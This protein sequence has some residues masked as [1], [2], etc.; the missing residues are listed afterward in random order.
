[1]RHPLKVD[2]LSASQR[3][4]DTLALVFDGAGK[5]ICELSDT[6]S[7][8][9]VIVDLDGVGAQTLL[10]EY[11]SQHP[12]RPIIALSVKQVN[13]SDVDEILVKPIKV[14][15][16]CAAMTR[17]AENLTRGSV[18]KKWNPIAELVPT[19]PAS[20]APRTPAPAPVDSEPSTQ[21]VPV[22]AQVLTQPEATEARLQPI[23]QKDYRK[24]CGN[25]VDIDLDDTGQAARILMPISGRLLGIILY[26][27]SESELQQVPI[28]VNLK[29]KHL[30]VI[31]PS[32]Q[33]ASFTLK[34]DMLQRLCEKSFPTGSFSFKAV[35]DLQPNLDDPL[36]ISK[37][38]MLWKTAAWTY[39]GKLPQD[40]QLHE[41]VYLRHWPNLTRLLDLP[42]AMRI[43]ALLVEQPMSLARTAEALS[44]PQRHVFAYYSAAQ[45]IG[46]VGR[47]KRSSDYLM[48]TPPPPVPDRPNRK[49]LGRMV[50]HLRKLLS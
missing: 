44:I 29:Q 3:M 19:F 33:L 17:V 11:R 18:R 16:L 49:L 4:R 28:A 1:M 42:D 5:N 15:D 39:C 25:A 38:Q 37:E 45:A 27:I 34:D 32:Q 8:E 36:T 50:H 35:P 21:T 48:D 43:S 40:T 26:A 10:A 31:F 13:L 46:L 20:A 47:A 24:V 12:D 14:H 9:A 41:R 30:F 7:A 23:P 6:A 2:L 22:P